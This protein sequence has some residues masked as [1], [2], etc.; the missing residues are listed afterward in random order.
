MHC[1][2]ECLGSE[3]TLTHGRTSYV[4]KL[5]KMTKEHVKEEGN[6]GHLIIKVTPEPDDR[7]W[8]KYYK[9]VKKRIGT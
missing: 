6:L 8:E 5:I 9:D 3:L 4:K 1:H 7:H 2:I